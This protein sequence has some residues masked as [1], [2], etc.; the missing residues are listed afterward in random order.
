MQV[1][2]Q[3]SWRLALTGWTPSGRSW[4]CG[5]VGQGGGG[6]G[7][8]KRRAA[9][10]RRRWRRRRMRWRR[11]WWWSRRR[12]KHRGCVLNSTSQSTQRLRAPPAA[13]AGTACQ[14]RMGKARRTRRGAAAAGMCWWRRRC[15]R[16]GWWRWRCGGVSVGVVSKGGN[17]PRFRDTIQHHRRNARRARA[18]APPET[19]VLPGGRATKHSRYTQYPI[20]GDFL[21]HSSPSNWPIMKSAKSSRVSHGCMPLGSS[22]GADVCHVLPVGEAA[23]A[24]VDVVEGAREEGGLAAVLVGVEVFQDEGEEELH[25]PRW[26]AG[27]SRRRPRRRG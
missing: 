11:W 20:S 5:G 9:R 26:S 24:D 19:M 8:R 23:G 7:G 22:D 13:K 14:E 1:R 21:I 16:H 12:W 27:W 10:W 4:N 25:E 15:R 18:R 6:G 3:Q 17:G 2:H